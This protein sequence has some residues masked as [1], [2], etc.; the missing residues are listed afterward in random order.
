MSKYPDYLNDEQIEAMGAEI[1]A[2]RDEV[3]SDLGEKD[4]RYMKRVIF[5]QQVFEILGRVGIFAGILYPVIWVFA[6][7]SLG[8]SKILENMEVGHNIMHSQFDWTNDPKLKGKDYEWDNV[9]PASSWRQ[10]HNYMHHTYT[11]IEGL[12]KDL[13]YDGMFRV[14]DEQEWKPEFR[15]QMFI[16][17]FIMLGFQNAVALHE[18]GVDDIRDGKRTYKEAWHIFKPIGWKMFRQIMKEFVLIPAIAV[19]A[20]FLFA[21][22]LMWQAYWMTALGA[23]LANIIRNVWAFLVIFCGHFTEGAHTFPQGTES[24]ETKAGW[25][26][27]Q[28]LG[29]C[30][31]KGGA[32]MNVMTGNLSHQIEHHLFPDMPANRYKE[33][34]PKIQAIAKKYGVPYDTG[35]FGNQLK[36][37]YRR[38]KHYSKPPEEVAA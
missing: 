4:V 11:N 32:L 12:D 6:V 1:Q 36:S 26:Y 34:A 23:L 15:Y 3:M 17:F 25:Y 22:E 33:V 38:L 31:I 18:L 21:P 19:G 5:V 2:V 16:G 28:M 8:L 10:T 29:S 7:I 37:V 35:T 24:N 20:A 9:C 13:G 27:R 30:N 14:C